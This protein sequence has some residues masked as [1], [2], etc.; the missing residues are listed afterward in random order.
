M[1]GVNEKEE[2]CHGHVSALCWNLLLFKYHPYFVFFSAS[3]MESGCFAI[4][5][6]TVCAGSHDGPMSIL[7]YVS[8]NMMTLNV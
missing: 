8:E 5:T 6:E 2:I 4:R 3:W 7:K 1:R